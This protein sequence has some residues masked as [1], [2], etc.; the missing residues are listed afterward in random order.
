MAV[1]EIPLS[2]V[3]PAFSFTTDLDGVTFNFEFRFN[4][5]MDLWIFDILDSLGTPIQLGNPF[6]TGFIFLRQNVSSSA[7][8]GDLIAVNT[9]ND[10]YKDA[11]RFSI[12]SIV[13]FQYIE[14]G[15]GI[16]D[17]VDGEAT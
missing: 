1:L 7:P 14:L 12:G 11:D 9:S 6:Y 4:T 3:D 13:K 15:T 17:P 16:A 5:R 10:L 2:N 8:L